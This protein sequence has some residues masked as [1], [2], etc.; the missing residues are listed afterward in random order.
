MLSQRCLTE[1][2]CMALASDNTNQLLA[3][4]YL[5]WTENLLRLY[6]GVLHCVIM[7]YNL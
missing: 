6:A 1:Y 3:A 7:C 5:G 4:V 2:D